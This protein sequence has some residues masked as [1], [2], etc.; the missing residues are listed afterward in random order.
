MQRRI[1]LRRRRR[2]IGLRR[3]V[4]VAL[5][6]TVA[7]VEFVR[8]GRDRVQPYRLAR[9]VVAGELTRRLDRRR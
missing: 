3:Q 9:R 6:R 7:D 2:E 8:L 1:E 4:Q 5:D